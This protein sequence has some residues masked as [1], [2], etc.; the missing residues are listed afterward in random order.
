MK[1]SIVGKIPSFLKAF[2]FLPLCS[3]SLLV[4][5]KRNYFLFW[6]DENNNPLETYIQFHLINKI[7]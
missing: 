2:Q 4:L 6:G 3:N 7:I 5:E 1:E